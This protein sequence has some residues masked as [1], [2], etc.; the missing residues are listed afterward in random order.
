MWRLNAIIPKIGECLD[1]KLPEALAYAGEAAD[2]KAAIKDFYVKESAAFPNRRPIP[3]EGERAY[4][5]RVKS[6]D[7][8]VDQARVRLRMEAKLAHK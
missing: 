4:E 8:G 3:G 5:R 6:D 1:T 2:L 7:Q